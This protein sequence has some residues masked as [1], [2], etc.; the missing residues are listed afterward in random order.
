MIR[1]TLFSCSIHI[2]VDSHH[3]HTRAE[4]YEENSENFFIAFIFRFVPL[5]QNLFVFGRTIYIE[6]DIKYYYVCIACAFS[7]SALFIADSSTPI[8]S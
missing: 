3:T 4:K 1:A 8:D 5:Q 2:A 7:Q 6:R